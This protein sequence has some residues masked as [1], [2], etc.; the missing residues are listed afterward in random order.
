MICPRCGSQG[1]ERLGVCPAC[2]L[3]GEPEPVVLGG[4]LELGEEIGRGGMGSVYK[5]RHLRLGRPVAV[6]LLPPSLSS[7]PEAEARFEREARALALLSHPHVVAV[8]DFGREDGQ[9]WIV[10]EYV[11]GPSLASQ[12]PLPPERVRELGLQICDAVAYAHARGVVHR[13]LKPE[14]VLLDGQ[15]RAKVGDFGIARIVGV[16][17][18]RVT[19]TSQVLGTPRY[20]APEALDGAPPD[21]RMDVYSLGVLLYKMLT[22]TEPAGVFPPAPA[23]FDAVIRKALSSDPAARYKDAGE[24]R[25][26]LAT[27][28]STS[29]LPP[30]ELSFLRG[31]AIL[32]SISTAVALWAFLVCVTPRIFDPGELL[33]LIALGSRTLADGRIHSPARFET[34]WIL[35]ALGALAPAIVAYGFLRRHW[36]TSG[37]QENAPERPVKDAARVFGGG[38]LALAIYGVR[39]SLEAAGVE[40]ATQF[41]PIAGGLLLVGVLYLFWCAVLEAW[42]TS[43]PLRREPQLW[44]GAALAVF[45]PLVELLRALR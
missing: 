25:D 1:D 12:L 21:P 44:I 7:D 13:D 39:R 26:A 11:D 23:P 19:S 28:T 5:A 40:A 41:L 45:A 6:K 43:R 38:V 4:A 9:S 34:G 2:V 42:R 22:G 24:L 8:H 31:V 37:L 27:G 33:P 30:E 14:N 35:A 3:G 20:I 32:Q 10:M 15:G 36:R 16:D 29:S 17:V 18:P